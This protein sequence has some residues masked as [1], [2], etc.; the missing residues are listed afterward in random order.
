MDRIICSCISLL[1]VC[2]IAIGQINPAA[3]CSYTLEIYDSAANGWD[4]AYLEISINNGPITNYTINTSQG[5]FTSY[6]LAAPNGSLIDINYVDE[7]PC[8]KSG[9]RKISVNLYKN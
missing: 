2:S 9:K 6:N 5:S 8:L 3:S 7:I 1:F 4:G